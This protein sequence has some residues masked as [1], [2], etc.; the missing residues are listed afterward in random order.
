MR[1][2]LG[3]ESLRLILDGPREG[4]LNMAL[5]E[6]LLES[7]TRPTL[8]LYSW[9]SPTLSLG[10]SQKADWL[11]PTVLA[12][13]GVSWVRR[14]T[15]GRT[16]LH[17]QEITYAIVIPDVGTRTVAQCYETLTAWLGQAL[18]HRGIKL[19]PA[20]VSRNSKG[21][22][23]CYNL[24]QKGELLAGENKLVGSAQAR[25]GPRLLQHGAIPLRVDGERLQRLMPGHL[26][27]PG[28]EDLGFKLTAPELAQ[29]LL[30]TAGLR[31]QE[32]PFTTDELA[33]AAPRPSG[34]PK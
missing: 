20:L 15:G 31:G 4:Q 28:L 11:D 18:H 16:L 10:F 21:H 23:G 33:C 34:G 6:Y 2:L 5:D 32:Q 25:R 7:A 9:S 24:Q 1:S 8:R 12:R 29:A 13:E 26:N 30:D 19:Q 14:P 27:Y 17:D 22:P 3:D